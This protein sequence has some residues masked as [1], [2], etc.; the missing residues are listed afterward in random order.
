MNSAFLRVRVRC[1]FLVFCGCFLLVATAAK[2]HAQGIFSTT[3]LGAG[4]F[5]ST[6]GLSTSK[7]YL[8]A[9][10]F[11]GGAVTINGVPFAASSGG[12][13][14]GTDF[15]ISGI[16]DTYSGFGS[17]VQGNLG[18][19]LSTFI[20]GGNNPS[21]VYTFSGLTPGQTY[22]VTYYTSSWEAAGARLQD[23][24][25]SDGGSTTYDVDM[26][27]PGQGYGNL[28]RYTFVANA[29]T[30][31]ITGTPVN[32]GNTWHTYGLSLEQTFNNTTQP[33]G[34]SNWS[35]LTWSTGTAPNGPDTN[36]SFLA[37]A[38]PTTI[39]LDTPV[40]LGYLQFAGSNSYLLSGANALTVQADAGGTALLN[41]MGGS[42]TISVPI[43]LNSNAA[44]LGSGTMTLSGAVSGSGGL[45]VNAGVLGL[46]AS[47]N[48]SGATT[49]VNGGTLNLLNTNALQNSTLI[50][51]GGAVV[52]DS[53]VGGHF[54]VGGLSGAGNLTLQDNAATPN[55]VTLSVGGNGASSTYAG[56]LSGA[57][58]LNKVGA[59]TLALTNG[60]NTYGGTIIGGGVL[61]FVSGALGGSTITFAGGT[62]QYAAGNTQDV[63]AS[64]Q[65]ST[66][67]IAIDSNGQRV[68]IAAPGGTN[69][70]GL[71]KLG[72]GVLGLSGN[73]G[74][75]GP[76]T[77]S[78]GTLQLGGLPPVL[79]NG[80]FASPNIGNNNF[81]YYP[82][83]TTAQQAQFVWTSSGNGGNGGGAI[84]NGASAWNYNTSYPVGS[85]AF[86][87]QNNSS[88]S[89]SLFFYPGVY[90]VSWYEASRQGQNNPYYFQLNGAD[91]GSTFS[92]TNTAWTQ[93]STNFTITTPGTYSIG[94][95]GTANPDNSVALNDVV[96]GVLSGGSPGSLPSLTAVN[97]T[98]S[99][100]ALD[101]SGAAQTIGSLT[102][103]AGSSVID[104][105]AL[106]SGNDN[107]NATFAG[108]ISGGGSVTKIG[109]G[110]M[111]LSGANT[112]TGATTVSSG[113]LTIGSA[114]SLVSTAASVSDG[115]T[116]NV[117]GSLPSATNL[118][119]N[120]TVNFSN[121]S[122][123]L[124][125]LTDAG[126]GTRSV[127]LNNTAL[128]VTGT[129]T[130]S[131]NI[132]GGGSL[133][134]TSSG[135]LTL[136]GNNLY[137]GPTTINNG[138]LLLSNAV[139]NNIAASSPV[140]VNAAGILDVSGLAGG[141]GIT[142]AS[143]QTLRGTGTVVGPVT[144]AAGS[145]LLSGTGN[146]TGTG[147]GTLTFT[148][149]LGLASG[150]TLVA[151]LGT[152]GSGTASLG[153]AGLINVQG[154]LTLPASGLNLSLL[155]NSGAGGLGSAGDGY[156]EL[157]SY[158]GNLSGFNAN[159]TFN[160]VMGKV[161]TFTNQNNQIDVRVAILALNWTGVN[162]NGL[163]ANSSW[164][165]T[166][167]STN[168][169]NTN[170]TAAVASAYQDGSNVTFSDTNPIT[171]K[172][173][174]GSNIVIQ[175]S[176]VQPNSV[177]FNNNAVNYTLSDSGGTAGIAGTT[178]IA[179][180]GSG[181]VYLQGPNSLQGTV[182]I[183]AGIVDI[184]NGAA[185]GVSSGV[186]VASGA[187]LQLQG[188]IAVGAL[189]LGLA[190]GGFAANPAGALNNVSG[191]NSYAG[192]VT[193]T[194]PATIAVAAGQLTLSGGINSNGNSLTIGGPGTTMITGT[195]S[196]TTNLIDNG[197]L[198]LTTAAQT[199][200]NFG[201]SGAGTSSLTLNNTALTV[202]GAGAFSGSISGGGSLTI[203]NGALLLTGSTS[204]PSMTVNG[205]VFQTA[206]VVTQTGAGGAL[207][208]GT[209][210]GTGVYN[211]SA[212]TVVANGGL[213]VGGPA[214]SVGNGT[215]NL[216]G[217]VVQATGGLTAGNGTT[218]I[219]L[220]PAILQSPAWT[221][222]NNGV[223]NININGG[224]LQANAG[225]TGFLG[226]A[227]STNVNVYAGGVV[228]DTQ[229]NNIAINQGLLGVGG[230]GITSVTI[231]RPDTTTVFA[232]P[233]AVTFSGG[234]G[235]G[236]SAYAT[237]SPSGTISGIVV[238]N[239]GS[240]T[241]PPNMSVNG[242][243]VV[244]EPT[245]T[246]NSL[247]GLTKN[248]AGVLTL[249]GT[250]TYGGPTVINAGT[251][252]VA[253]GKPAGTAAYY[254][255]DG[256]TADLSGNA[257]NGTI[258]SGAATYT[259]GQF[260]QAI[261]LN[262]SQS[263][264]VPNSASLQ[265]SNNFTVSG[266]FNLNAAGMGSNVNGIVGTRFGQ[267]ETFD[268]KVDGPGQLI[269]GDVGNGSGWISTG[270]D[271]DNLSFG[272]GQWHMVTY[273]VTPTGAQ[274][275]F[276]GVDKQNY[277]WASNTPT[278]M[279]AAAGA[280]MQIGDSSGTEYMNGAIDDVSVYGRALT[281][282]QVQ[283][284]YQGSLPAQLPATSA[285]SIANN[286]TLDLNGTSQTVASLADIVS[287][288]GGLVT[289]SGGGSVTLTLNPAPNA[290]NT[291]S[292]TIQDG[293][294]KVSVSF[295]GDISAT[296]VLT[297][298]NTFSGTANCGL[299]E[300]VL[301][302]SGA[303][304]GATVYATTDSFVVFDKSVASHAFTF[305]GL[306]GSYN[307]LL[308]DNANNP[309]ALSVGS[310]N[311]N[312]TYSGSLSD[313]GVGGSFI[314]IGTGIQ[315]LA[316][317]SSFASGNGYSG[318]TFINGGELS[319]A[320]SGALPE[321]GTITFDGS[322]LQP[323][324]LQYTAANTVDY[325]AQIHNSTAPVAIDTNGQNV[326]FASPLDAT[327]TGGFAKAGAGILTFAASNA[328]GGPT[329]LVGG[330]LSLANA[331]AIPS[332]GA[333]TFLGGALQYT[334]SNT[335][336]YSAQI[337]NSTGPIWID[338][339][340]Q[341]VTFASPLD[342]SNVGGL[343]KSGSGTLALSVANAYSG[344]TTVAGG[345]LQLQN[346]AGVPD[347]TALAVSGGTFDLNGYSK[348]LNVV[349]QA[350]TGG[351]ITS[352]SAGAAVTLNLAL[353]PSTA[354]EL[355]TGTTFS[356]GAGTLALVLSSNNGSGLQ[357]TSSN[358]FSGGTTIN[359]SYV[360][361]NNPSAL[362]TGPINISNGGF[363][364]LWWNTGS[365]TLANNFVLNTI[366]G[367]Q[368]GSQQPNQKAAIFAD[369]GGG[370][371]VGATPAGTYTLTGSITLAA[372]GGIDAFP[373]NPLLVEG[374]I[375]GP[376][377]L[378]KGIAGGGNGGG[379]VTLTNTNNSYQ[380][381]TTLNN[382]V[383]DFVAGALPFSTTSPNIVFN[384]GT[385]QWA[386]SNTQDVSAG[387]APIAFGQSAMTDTNGNTVHF[388]T[389]LS[390]AGGLTKIGAGTL[391][392]GAVN[393]Y[394]GTTNI[395]GGTLS[396]NNAS[397]IPSGG[398]ITFGG[399][400]LQYT[401]ASSG[402]DYS[403]LNQIINSGG[404]IAIDTNGQSVTFNGNLPASNTGG[405]DKIGAG[406]LTLN[407]SN[408]YAGATTINGG[409]L[410]LGSALPTGS[411]VTFRGGTLQYTASTSSVDYSSVIQ[412]STGP[413]AIDTNGQNVTFNSSMGSSNT[414]G[415]TKIGAGTLV[416]AS[417]AANAYGGPTVIQGGTLQ[418]KLLGAGSL[419]P[420]TTPSFT[421]DATSGIGASPLPYTEALAFNQGANLTINGV[422][423][424]NANNASGT[425]NLGSNWA[426]SPAI[427]NPY[428]NTAA[429]NAPTGF[430]PASG[431]GTYSLFSAFY[432]EGSTNNGTVTLTLSG[433]VP[434]QN[435]DA[436]VYY[437][438]FAST[439]PDNRI[440]D[441]TFTNGISAQTAV[442]NEDANA[443]GNY[444]DY[445]YTASSAGTAS[446]S[447]TND[448]N[449]IAGGSW[450]WYGFS[451]QLVPALSNLLPTTTSLSIAASSTLDLN[452]ASQQVVS[453]SDNTPGHGGNVINS[454]A[455]S[456]SVL[457]L[458]PAGSTTFSGT[459]GDNG[460]GNSPG[461]IAL[462]L[463]GPGTMVLSGTNTYTGG[464]TV[465]G[466]TLVLTNN[467]AIADGTS[468][469]VGSAAELALFTTPPVSPLSAAAAT[470]STG[471]PAALSAV[472][473][474]GTLVLLGAA[475]FLAAAAAWR[476]RRR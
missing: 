123:T 426:F 212:G 287:G 133:T 400:V 321:T 357:I 43:V 202:T 260:G 361:L 1:L 24:V 270:L 112:Y 107:T 325:S 275:Y 459:I 22:V 355:I 367:A 142:L 182:A 46:A 419:S 156:Y 324:A 397:A 377:G 13:P 373:S 114:G 256:S 322:L 247:G 344:T 164:D 115:A 204:L 379:L 49:S 467:E 50:P 32:A 300:L 62:L 440:A 423:F 405:L 386:A 57:G 147:I 21:S 161:F 369:G 167:S 284:L 364:M 30:E 240:Y 313:G 420:V 148:N 224:T 431:Q 251:L 424:A 5:D 429:F 396:A 113:T 334:A 209:A 460:T 58:N 192:A 470:G 26:G 14:S 130:F 436:R 438:A 451:N 475:G 162:S 464:T 197:A 289:N 273:V 372:N 67:P 180:S 183:N 4:K 187:A 258:S 406:T 376:G 141:S 9:V 86:S 250:S 366:G 19:L 371:Y 354:A 35:A 45:S 201:D 170:G 186:S 20:Y 352:S 76:T 99:S 184:S 296:Q 443:T 254:P 433:L 218:T 119:A 319:M 191:T 356:D 207:S 154:N 473:E 143:G 101:L 179:K 472:P 89:E 80:S 330:E 323:G 291:F 81:V 69:T 85:Q 175:P 341:N 132:S 303:L 136:T 211:L 360:R 208:V 44:Q 235:S 463:D 121:A 261:A 471:Y 2:T 242:S 216:T 297:G 74:Y 93:V 476:R 274:L 302:N 262:G 198:T 259:S 78:G 437:R 226:T 317:D 51:G 205:S 414:S 343:T 246:S 461:S 288:Q 203:S 452:G 163:T 351:L 263:V 66:A 18:T 468:L 12:N 210:G 127:T 185:L 338:T 375:S 213:V 42:H 190:G 214:G 144:V 131:G 47:N 335:V 63:G 439:V 159:T 350:L 316:G 238:T 173:V 33:S 332:G 230:G 309:V 453:L 239:P 333:L 77:I 304:L 64:I 34:N 153:N 165:T 312:S 75:S 221:A 359:D 445:Q 290:V 92:T 449:M 326:T 166:T 320:N 266:W 244:F 285:V 169:A 298:V 193:L 68:I 340:G 60:A 152:P 37:A 124:A 231:A 116:L 427:A 252:Q 466:G 178:G 301:A 28:L 255:F 311:Q 225:G 229:G 104:T 268:L 134:V 411:T 388:A 97:L 299:S 15:S 409:T 227:P 122:Q 457:T 336:D 39:T 294:G 206:G 456:P 337:F 87:L 434:G 96:L 342:A 54:N 425:G 277:T 390:G 220:G 278:F 447:E 52:F 168:W 417:A 249:G 295:Q 348:N 279:T 308:A 346:Q 73:S 56:L 446:I 16:P 286:A 243:S 172:P 40:T 103:V 253:S 120:G 435:Y 267:D 79:Q 381:G 10:N 450:H 155:N 370:G 328:Y 315:T 140:T 196:P 271:I 118:T 236:A 228:I 11:N 23:V 95:L 223:V 362:G 269:H 363:V 17:Q 378:F 189:P 232:T 195:M 234:A 276:D 462:L 110:M 138:T 98:A 442:V 41:A 408:A 465:L 48:F 151:Y 368:V 70:G 384:G 387:I 412:N 395:N 248:G 339:N 109:T 126:A 380:G 194:A 293:A 310:N 27:A 188:G 3:Y 222:V 199:I 331:A 305:G 7:T 29:A 327:N 160:P 257:N 264:I 106:I 8:T 100:A 237:L 441:F 306:S 157:F 469:A 158:S 272:A 382:G 404:A 353:V 416:L 139:S 83:L 59:G 314:K 454:N 176:G 6:V 383:L 394:G 82:N 401:A 402:N 25:T 102:G 150:A 418:L 458:T 88:L 385:L 174:T 72:A 31:T 292:G 393:S 345:V 128:A 432:Y 181:T 241:S 65:N 349:S 108:T 448:A 392:L 137:T 53:S 413:V 146:A 38:A 245:L 358:A 55:P 215:L 398:A 282:T 283:G 474:P 219:N 105:G 171:G 422:T 217:G 177:A 125:T 281:A 365:G 84:V 135:A 391:V 430:L 71:T 280:Q 347:N 307:W 61:N 444:I 318:G 428:P 399:G 374:P 145:T 129:S 90:T 455:G 36:A 149:S 410:S 265:L 111:F 117:A 389:G 233:P 407:G 329:Y 403:S 94:F 200:A 421:S 415:L 91:V